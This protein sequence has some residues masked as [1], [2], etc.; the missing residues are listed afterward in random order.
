MLARARI[1]VAWSVVAAGGAARL[2]AQITARPT[3]A[4]VESLLATG[5]YERARETATRLTREHPRDPASFDWL[6]R[7]LVA[8]PSPRLLEG[9]QAFRE[10]ARQSPGDTIAW[11]GT[12][13]AALRLGGADGERLARD[14]LERLLALDPARPWAWEQ[15]LTLYRSS[16][17]RSRVRRLLSPRRADSRAAERIALLLIEDGYYGPANGMLDGVLAADRDDPTA[18]ALRAQSAFESG[19]DS[20]GFVFYESALRAANRDP[21]PLWRQVIGIATPEELRAWAAGPADAEQF[22]RAF[23]AR[24]RTSLFAATNARIAEHF[25]RLQVARARWPREHPLVNYQQREAS[26]WLQ[27]TPSAAEELFFQR[28]EVRQFLRRPGIGVRSDAARAD[29]QVSPAMTLALGQL[30]DNRKTQPI[31]DYVPQPGVMVL[32]GAAPL[33]ELGRYNRSLLDMDSAGVAPGYGQRT[34]LDDRGLLYLRYGEPRRRLVSPPNVEDPFCRVPD[35]ELWEY[36]GL[37]TVRFFRPSA[38]SVFGAGESGRQTGDIVLRPMN[39][40]QFVASAIAVTHDSAS[41]PA[42]LS[43]GA[44]FSQLRG[45]RSGLTALVVATTRGVAAG[46]VVPDG[47]LPGEVGRSDAGVLNLEAHPG[48]ATLLVN[49]QVGDTLGRQTLAVAVRSFER[50]PAVSDLLVARPWGDTLVTRAALVAALSRD[51]TF[52][53][54]ARL[55]AAVEVY[56]LRADQ[57]GRGQYEVSY[58]LLRS[59]QPVRQMSQDTLT[60][61]AV[62]SFDRERPVRGDVALEWVDIGTDRYEPGKYLLR[63]DISVGGR[64]IGRAQAAVT[65][66]E[67]GGR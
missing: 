8:G 50:T 23:W 3:P 32:S 12:A 64:R 14:A 13:A 18:L 55:R 5:D 21:G 46:Q 15:Y 20:T 6:G 33:A 26:R 40:P 17:D 37:G 61:A 10:A 53:I 39:D 58:W 67:P 41:V 42:L 24:R 30:P 27:A 7:A 62:L 29:P 66:V 59:S 16:G 63:V 31:T 35:L 11:R 47:G 38:V 4:A 56:G 44:W 52:E 65:L 60:R 57:D 25:H 2:P 9:I 1:L 51:L 19:E 48:R 34:G 22:L 43:F 28:C 49:G 45:S 54:G 36:P